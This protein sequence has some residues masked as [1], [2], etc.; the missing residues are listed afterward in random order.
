MVTKCL[1]GA[2]QKLRKSL[3]SNTVTG[4]HASFIAIHILSSALLRAHDAIRLSIR[5]FVPSIH[6]SFLAAT[7]NSKAHDNKRDEGGDEAARGEGGDEACVFDVDVCE[8][9]DVCGGGD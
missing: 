1:Q 5:S 9:A 7:S 8:R 2:C 4:L 6:A 3:S